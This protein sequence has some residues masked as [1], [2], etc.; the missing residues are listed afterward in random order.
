MITLSAES[1]DAYR[2]AERR[3][4]LAFRDQDDGDA[5]SAIGPGTGA[6]T[7]TGHVRVTTES[8]ASAV[9][10]F[11]EP[12]D[13]VRVLARWETN[14][15]TGSA[16][17]ETPAGRWQAQGW[18]RRNGRWTAMP[19]AVVPVR[20]E[21][22]SRMRGLLET[23]ILSE[24]RV[25]ILGLGSGGSRIAL[26]LAQ[27]G[28]GHLTLMDDDRVEVANVVRHIAGLSDIG[29]FKTKV[30][31]RQCRE[32]NPYIEIETYE[33]K[34][35]WDIE[36]ILRK[37]VRRSSL[38]ICAVDRHD[39][40]LMINKVCVDEDTPLIVAACFRRA[41]GGQVL[42]VRPGEGP[43]FQCYVMALPDKADDQE[44]TSQEQ[45]DGIAYSDRP[46]PVEPGLANDIEPVNQVVVKLAIQTL[47][48][49]KQTTLRSL[50]EDLAAPWYLWLNRREENTEYATLEPLE[51]NVDG[52]HVLRW[53]GIDLKRD[54]ACPCC[55][56]YAEYLLKQ[57]GIRPD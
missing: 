22:F 24:A 2:G 8:R 9:D 45:A 49:G 50:D 33:C 11:G 21:I 41:Y 17:G 30:V 29:R 16:N 1:L 57:A 44:I 18:V 10:D 27:A 53:Y 56:N 3:L 39:P 7:V 19:V 23:D 47:L 12:S 43:C 13:T 6:R 20:E 54:P 15:D 31:A 38:A 35:G 52:L 14:A 40:R 51:F 48:R 32:K 28:V 5:Y 42:A 46:V 55:G 36:D 37:A 25:L 34:A 4:K 26:G